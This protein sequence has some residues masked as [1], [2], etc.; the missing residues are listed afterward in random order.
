MSSPMTNK[1]SMFQ[2]AASSYGTAQ[3]ATGG[4]EYFVD[5]AGGWTPDTKL[6]EAKAQAARAQGML[7]RT[8]RNVFPRYNGSYSHNLWSHDDEFLWAACLPGLVAPANPQTVGGVTVHD[9]EYHS[10]VDGFTERMRS[11]TIVQEVDKRKVGAASV[12]E[13]Y[14]FSGCKV[15]DW[16]LDMPE[17]D[18]VKL[19]T[20]W[21]A[22][23]R[24]PSEETAN[25]VAAA[26]SATSGEPRPFGYD[27]VT[28][29]IGVGGTASSTGLGYIRNVTVN[30]DNKLYVERDYQDGTSN[31]EEPYSVDAAMGTVS[32]TADL[33]DVTDTAFFDRFIASGTFSL[34]TEITSSPY[35]LNLWIPHVYLTTADPEPRNTPAGATVLTVEG[36]IM[37]ELGSTDNMVELTYTTEGNTNP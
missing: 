2:E 34:L 10:T 35:K 4:R 21:V 22:Q 5:S 11:F 1:M 31:M 33:A 6:L 37:Y 17:N 27:D 7:T 23:G 36:D 32:I 8:R 14:V 13:R 28:H 16:S 15:K 24:A 19:T 25:I 26:A 3:V 18:L 29:K 20:N 12:M 9:K 30:Y